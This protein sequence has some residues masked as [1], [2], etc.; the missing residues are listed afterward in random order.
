MELLFNVDLALLDE[1]LQVAAEPRDLGEGETV[2][3][4]VD[5]LS[6]EVW[7]GSVA[8]GGCGVAVGAEKLLLELDGADGRV[9]L[10]RSVEATVVGARHGGEKLC[11]PGTAETAVVGEAVV[12]EEGA[13]GGDGDK[14][15]L[16]AEVEDVL[17]IPDAVEA[18]AVSDLVLVK[19]DLV[20]AFECA[21]DDEL[22]AL[23]IER[24]QDDRG[25]GL[26]FDRRQ[27]R[28]MGSGA[29]YADHGNGL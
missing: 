2:F 11:S 20:R 12:D 9:Y 26:F 18:F 8:V 6:G 22:A 24:R 29:N 19:E 5:G 23:V 21:R 17:V 4:D 15:A 13:A 7:G 10:E 16:A 14:Q 28:R 1:R 27:R 25:G 3:G